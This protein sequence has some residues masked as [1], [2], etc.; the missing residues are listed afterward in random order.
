MELIAVWVVLAVAVGILAGRYGRSGFGWF[1]FALILSPLLG[2]ILVLA[3][4][5]KHQLIYLA[6]APH[7]VA[8]KKPSFDKTSGLRAVL[9][10]TVVVVIPFIVW[11]CDKRNGLSVSEALKSGGQSIFSKSQ[12]GDQ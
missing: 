5:S 3:L 12:D 10:L 4:G 6:H 2:F 11:Q 7:A 9:F 1:L 8:A